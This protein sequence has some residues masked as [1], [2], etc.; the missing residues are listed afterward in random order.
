MHLIEIYMQLGHFENESFIVDSVDWTGFDLAGFESA[1]F[2][3]ASL[4]FEI[5]HKNSVA[6]PNTF[7]FVLN[8][9]T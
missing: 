6:D 7:G 4:G 2:N 9:C 5:Y 3:S 8:V 1:E